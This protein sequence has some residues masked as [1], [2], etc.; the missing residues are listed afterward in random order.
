MGFNVADNMNTENSLVTLKNVLKLKKD[1]T[2]L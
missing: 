1:K 2:L